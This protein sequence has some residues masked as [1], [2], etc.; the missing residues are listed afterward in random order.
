MSLAIALVAAY[1]VHLLYTALVLDWWGVG[2]GPARTPTRRLA[3]GFAGVA[4]TTEVR[5][6][7]LAAASFGAALLAAVACWA[8]FGGAM[9][10]AVAGLVGSASPTLGLRARAARRRATGAEVWPRL[11]EGIRVEAVT[12]GRSVPQALFEVGRLAPPAMQRA[13]EA[14]R[15]SW[16]LSADLGRALEVL[17]AG[18][19]DPTADV[20]CE[21]LLVAHQ[22]GGADVDRCLRA[23]A[24]DRQ[25][26]LDGRRDAAAHQAGARFARSFTLAV[27]L[28]MALVGMGIGDGRAAYGTPTGQVLVATAVAVMVGCWVWAGRTLRL[29]TAR[30]VFV[31]ASR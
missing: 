6:G 5:P 3:V 15:R 28:G 24:E 8:V 11:I 4:R 9:A 19:D 25:A 2:P 14:A 21:T 23:L 22:V 29:P 10:S 1:G 12:L 7:E 30:R 27:P 26:D 17:R 13:F 20:V 31:G 18:L 16:L